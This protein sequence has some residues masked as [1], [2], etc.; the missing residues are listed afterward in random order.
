M[1]KQSKLK[2]DVK[3][4]FDSS[5]GLSFMCDRSTNNQERSGTVDLFKGKKKIIEELQQVL[6]ISTE[7]TSRRLLLKK[8]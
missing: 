3:Y 8:Y 2:K 6:E 5:S 7:Q 1:T 4:I